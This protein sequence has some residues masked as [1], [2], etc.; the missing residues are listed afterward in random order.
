MFTGLSIGIVAAFVWSITNLVDKYL[1]DKYTTGGN[2]GGVLLLSCFFPFLLI[3]VIAFVAPEHILNVSLLELG[4]LM[5]AG[6]LMVL[7]IY[8]YLKALSTDD[9]SVVMTLLVLS[10]F[11]SLIFAQQILHEM[12]TSFQLIA[13]IFLVAGA[14]TVVYEPR[15]HHFKWTLLGYAIAASTTT[16]LMGSLFKFAVIDVGVWESLFWR[17]SGMVLIGSCL[18]L[19]VRQFRH[20]FY[21][22]MRAHFGQAVGLNV[23]NESMTLAGDTLF[24]F[25]MLFAPLALLQT[26][27]AYQPV[28]IFIMV[29]VLN[30]FGFTAVSE[31][32]ERRTLVQK[33]TGFGLVLTGTVLLAVSA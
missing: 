31:N 15:T 33:G 5:A 29:L 30:H 9:S 3:L 28:F 8:F 4:V 18:F 10:P 23:T 2:I 20:D 25:G 17:S 11:F 27:E 22:F 32:I 26:T 6:A 24:A 14:L 1:V 12:P 13:G 21:A 7:W 16:G 19:F